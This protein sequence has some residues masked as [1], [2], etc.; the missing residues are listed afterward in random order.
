MGGANVSLSRKSSQQSELP[1]QILGYLAR[2][3][4]AQDSLEGILQWW[5]LEQQIMHWESQVRETLDEL[6]AQELLIEHVGGDGRTHYRINRRK[7]A[8]IRALLQPG[9]E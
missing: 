5:L 2:H 6:V 3:P 1:R 7:A 4:D 9:P 8:Q